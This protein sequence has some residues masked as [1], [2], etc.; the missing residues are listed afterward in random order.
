MLRIISYSLYIASNI[1]ENISC[2]GVP[3]KQAI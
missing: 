1:A 2:M 3:T